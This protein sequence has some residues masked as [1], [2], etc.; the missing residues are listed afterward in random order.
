MAGEPPVDGEN[1]FADVRDD[2]YYV[3]AIIWAYDKKIVGGLDG[4]TRFEPEEF[5]TREQIAKMLY[6][7]GKSQG[8]TLDDSADLSGFPD[9]SDV[10][11]WAL[12]YMRWAVGSGMINGKNIGGAYYLDPKGNATRAECAAMLTRFMKNIH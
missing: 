6:E 9:N 5:I 12:D 2:K 4:G 7:F 10:S 1:C 11:G 8:Y 3:Q